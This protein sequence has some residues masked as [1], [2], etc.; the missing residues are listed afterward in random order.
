MSILTV[1]GAVLIFSLLIIGH[2]L[3]HFVMAKING[4]K[5][6]EFSIGMGP[7]IYSIKGKETAYS[8]RVLPIG[9]Y[10][11][12]LGEGEELNSDDRA[13]SSKSPGRKLSVIA[14][15]PIMNLIIAV[16]YFSISYG[17]SG[18]RI[19]IIG[20]IVPDSAAQKCNLQVGDKLTKIGDKVINNW[21]DII[22]ALSGSKGEKIN[23][24][25]VRN[26]K[27]SNV[28]CIPQ[29]D[30]SGRYIIGFEAQVKKYSVLQSIR[31]GFGDTKYTV[32]QTIGFFGTLFQ[33]KAKS[34]DI[35]G[36]VTIIK[37]TGEVAKLGFASLF[38]F[39][40]YLSV[41][42]AI[43][44]FIPFPALDGGFIVLYLYELITKKHINA[45]KV[46]VINYIGFTILMILM[47]LVFI[48][49]I[50]Y[51]INLPF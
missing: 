46:G 15:G 27:A 21:E 49:D 29:K 4:I 37:L 18:Y 20:K 19:P 28:D 41:Q 42:L 38:S 7:K 1:V 39:N 9:G 33:G 11:K 30:K 35:G 10:V 45:N 32:E 26:D 2:E 34:S 44:N 12:M 51:P 13:F 40:G 48:K 50:L 22:I 36:P 8:L 6:E 25:Y 23:I 5:V 47:A 16:I 17:I 43:F 14:A 3:G 24:S 31:K